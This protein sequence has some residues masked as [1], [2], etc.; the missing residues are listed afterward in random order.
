MNQDGVSKKRKLGD[1]SPD[2]WNEEGTDDASIQEQ[3][4]KLSQLLE[5]FSRDQLVEILTSA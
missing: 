3:K 1:T 2:K 5:P 4:G